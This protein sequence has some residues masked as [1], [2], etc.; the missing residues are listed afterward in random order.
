MM[1]IDG[2]MCV[3]VLYVHRRK[4][5]LWQ[6]TYK[7]HIFT[8]SLLRSQ[9]HLPMVA[10]NPTKPL[11]H[12][13]LFTTCHSILRLVMTFCRIF[14]ITN[15]VKI[16]GFFPLQTLKLLF[17]SML[18][19]TC[20]FLIVSLISSNIL[21]PNENV[22]QK[23]LYSFKSRKAANGIEIWKSIISW[24]PNDFQSMDKF[25]SSKVFSHSYAMSL[26]QKHTH[27]THQMAES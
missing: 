2:V 21:I 6:S 9:Q 13:I 4:I 10:P 25:A 8:R 1:K 18:S 15:S 23:N 7:K 16:S 11:A 20:F 24:R 5:Y 26:P 19:C 22:H 17:L 12:P 14:L 3:N 27:H